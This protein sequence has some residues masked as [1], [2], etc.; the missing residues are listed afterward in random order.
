MLRADAD[1]ASSD[2][3]NADQNGVARSGGT[4]SHFLLITYAIAHTQITATVIVIDQRPARPNE[5]VTSSGKKSNSASTVKA[6]SMR[7]DTE[8]IC[9]PG[10]RDNFRQRAQR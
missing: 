5:W 1:G 3:G 2:S 10:T 4:R 8:E 9:R 6:G 7:S